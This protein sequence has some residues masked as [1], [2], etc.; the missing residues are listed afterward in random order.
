MRMVNAGCGAVMGAETSMCEW[1]WAPVSQCDAQ[2]LIVES[3]R[4]VD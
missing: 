2:I 3:M 4:A 1:T